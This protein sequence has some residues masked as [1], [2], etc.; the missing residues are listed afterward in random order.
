MGFYSPHSLVQDARRHGVEVLGPDVNASA[1]KATLEQPVGGNSGRHPATISSDGSTWGRDGPR[2]RLGIESV[3]H[4][5]ED[6][7]ET[8]AAGRP[9]RDMEDLARRTGAS[10]AVLEALATAGAFGCFELERR[11][12]LWGAGAV[13]QSGADRLPGV[14]TGVEAPTLPGMS[15]RE[16]SSAD[17]WATGV[18]ADG[19]PTKF[20]RPLLDDLGVTPA[21][22]LAALEDRSKVVV[23]GVVTHRQRPAT[24]SGITFLNLEDETG[25]INVVCSKG[26]WTRY[27][28]AA[29]SAP[30]LLIRGRLEKAEGVINVNAEKMEP[31]PLA[32]ATKSRDF[33]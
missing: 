3:R 28:R 22:G 19:H 30:A 25:L 23:A 18:S 24:A 9:Y 6:L 32:A 7:A 33:R 21:S 4:V 10:L 12:A 15:D 11:P 8:I 1:A 17:L 14:V 29:R 26:C 27:R 5:G 13:A 20:V 31:L 2:V 16:L